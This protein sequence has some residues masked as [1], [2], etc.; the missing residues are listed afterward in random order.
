MAPL[1][2]RMPVMIRPE[3]FRWWLEQKPGI[4]VYRSSQNSPLEVPLK[5][6][7]VSNVANSVKVDDPRCIEPVSIT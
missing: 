3:Q 1:H 7:S 5:I 4:D 2:D 6:Y